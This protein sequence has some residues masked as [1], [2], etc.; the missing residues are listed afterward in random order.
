MEEA[1]K[2][3]LSL[4]ITLVPG[5]LAFHCMRKPSHGLYWLLIPALSLAFTS[6]FLSHSVGPVRG[7][8]LLMFL[9]GLPICG[10]IAIKFLRSQP[11]PSDSGTGL[12]PD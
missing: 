9:S 8:G 7:P 12:N 3:L 5:L 10:A 6:S 4:V 11:R 2:P 1:L